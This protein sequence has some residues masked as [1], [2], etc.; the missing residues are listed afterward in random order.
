MSEEGV[1]DVEF[2]AFELYSNCTEMLPKEDEGK[3]EFLPVMPIFDA[4]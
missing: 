3:I 4:F 1:I 2:D